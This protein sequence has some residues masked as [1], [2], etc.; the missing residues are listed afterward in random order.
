MHRLMH[1]LDVIGNRGN[2]PD[3]R[4][5]QHLSL[6]ITDGFQYIGAQEDVVLDGPQQ[7]YE[8]WRCRAV[9]R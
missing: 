9:S 6:K 2:T 4:V 5:P 7:G 3:A 1:P 8:A